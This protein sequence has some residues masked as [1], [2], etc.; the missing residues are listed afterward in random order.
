M[1]DFNLS[2]WQEVF[3]FILTINYDSVHVISSSIVFISHLGIYVP[4]SCAKYILKM[5]VDSEWLVY[6]WA[7]A[8]NLNPFSN[9]QIVSLLRKVT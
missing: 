2:L 8:L 3:L 4:V 9:D 5:L 6:E 7:N 1:L